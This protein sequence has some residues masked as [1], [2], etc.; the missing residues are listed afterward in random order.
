MDLMR[1]IVDRS[2]VRSYADR[3][4]PPELLEQVLQAGVCAPS[5]NNSRPWH[6]VVAQRE[7]LRQAL[8]QT[9]EWSTFA[10]GAPVVLVICGDRRQSETYWIEDC[11]AAVE[12][13]LL[14]AHALGLASCWIAV[15][16]E[17]G[18]SERHVRGVL[19]IPEHVGVLALLPLGYPAQAAAARAPRPAAAHVHRETW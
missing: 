12:N 7:D 18:E 17:T 8:A 14:A 6:I 11:S 1:A 2:S 3:P 13:M 9:H 16:G 19:G 4:V 15:R 5:A 10:A